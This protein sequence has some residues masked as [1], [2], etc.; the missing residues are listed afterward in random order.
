[1]APKAQHLPS[2]KGKAPI[3]QKLAYELRYRQGYTYLDKCGRIVNLI[4]RD[5]PEWVLQA[6]Q[7][8][9]QNAPLVSL[10]NASV[11]T[12]SS[13]NLALGLEKP[14]GQGPLSPEDVDRFIDQ[15]DALTA[16]VI[17]QLGV[18]QEQLTRIGFR[19][20]YAF[21]CRDREDSEAWLREL[22]CYDVN[23]RLPAAFK[24][25]LDALSVS[26]VIKGEDR[27]FRIVFNGAE[28]QVQLDLGEAILTVKP[29]DLRE[30]QKKFLTDQLK[31]KSRV[32][33][34]P[35]WIAIVDIDC[36]QEDPQVLEVRDFLV[37]S[38]EQGLARLRQAVEGKGSGNG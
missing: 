3:L 19:I 2:I 31:A 35:E 18:G 13:V 25:A 26:V 8:S 10:R 22:G 36:Y 5:H 7:V 6:D 37:S 24:G 32:R 23:E 38:W 29:R 4:Q 28:R 20:W 14:L 17:D 16:L 33:Q 11:F 9:P 34:N 12:F 1:M 15:A 30:G 27:Y 21:G